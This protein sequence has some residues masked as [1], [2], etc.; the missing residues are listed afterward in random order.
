MII[1]VFRARPRPGREVAYERMIREDSVDLV[2]RQPGL[3]ALHVGK[4]LDGSGELVMVSVWTDLESVQA[5]AGTDWQTPV[6]LPGEDELVEQTTVTNY[7]SW[8]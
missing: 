4:A 8:T 6:A 5:F 3:V 7:E 2:Q 1:R